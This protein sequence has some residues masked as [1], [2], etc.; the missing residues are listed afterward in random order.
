MPLATFKSESYSAGAAWHLRKQE[1]KE[2]KAASFE[3]GLP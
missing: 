3:K 1:A 2:A